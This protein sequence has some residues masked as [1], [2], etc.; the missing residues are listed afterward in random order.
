MQISAI[1]TF[2]TYKKEVSLLQNSDAMSL[3][4]RLAKEASLDSS[5]VQEDSH[6]SLIL[7]KETEFV[8]VDKNIVKLSEGGRNF[9]ELLGISVED[10]KHTVF[11]FFGKK[12]A[13]FLKAKS[14]KLLTPRYA[15]A[16][17]S[18]VILALSSYLYTQL[19]PEQ[20]TTER[21]EQLKVSL[22]DH[23]EV[24]LNSES[25]LVLTKDFNKSSRDVKLVGEGFFNVRE[26]TLPFI[27]NTDIASIRVLGTQFNVKARE[28]WFEV[29]VKRGVVE[30]SSNVSGKDSSVILTDSQFT[31]FQKGE[32]PYP[33]QLIPLEQYPGWIIGKLAF[34]ETSLKLAIEEIE[35]HFD[36]TITLNDRSLEEVKISGLFETNDLDNILDA[37]CQLTKRNY[38]RLKN[39]KYI[40][41]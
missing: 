25:K 6:D 10:G 40:I 26:D 37:I 2:H 7:L 14:V 30:V 13:I 28:S 33:P 35:R 27:I 12:I 1:E 3:L 41:Y 4:L 23:S 15:L 29:A 22:D 16:A 18:M 11:E 24:Q 8:T 31:R 19:G 21:K 34:Y 9:L 17:V 20:Y 36:V 5:S 39:E 32:Y 38:R